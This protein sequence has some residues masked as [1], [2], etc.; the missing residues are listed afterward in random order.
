M[1]VDMSGSFPSPF[2]SMQ[3]VGEVGTAKS[4]IMKQYA[5]SKKND[6]LEYKCI[7]F[8]SLTTPNMLQTALESFLEK[9]QGRSY[10]PMGG[11]EL[12]IVLDDLSMPQQNEWGDQTTNELTRQLMEH[13]AFY[14]LNKPVGEMNQVIDSTFIMACTKA[15][16]EDIGLPNRLKGNLTPIFIPEP[17]NGTILS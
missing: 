9:R 2:F 11:K 3:I 13:S 8:S 12:I 15:V 4:S 14:R 17:R 5:N 6:N 16:S 1:G 10:G 7:T